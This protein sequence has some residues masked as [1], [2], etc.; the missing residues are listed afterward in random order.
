MATATRIDRA[1][2]S[3]AELFDHYRSRRPTSYAITVEVDV[4]E[5]RGRLAESGYKTY[6]TLIWALAT[7]VNR[8]PEFRMTLD[9]DGEPAVWDVVDPSFTV[10][11]T[12]RETFANVWTAY[13]PDFEAFHDRAAGLL[14]EYR[15][16]SELFPQGFPPPSN[17]F[18]ISSLP[19]TSFTG[20]TLSLENAH[21]HLAPNVTIGRF[22]ERNRERF[23]P[24]A[25]Q[26]HHAAADGYH[27]GRLLSA[28]QDLLHDPTWMR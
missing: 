15:H 13:D 25:L 26:I 22:V 2:W 12:E 27:V 23:M 7:V 9:E 19:W 10:L 3:R 14:A 17:L 21:D 16:A 11:N 28:L 8:Y 1:T 20:F 5:L 24:L 4:T 6:P 18:D